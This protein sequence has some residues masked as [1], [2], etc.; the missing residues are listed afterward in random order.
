[1][2]VYEIITQGVMGRQISHD[3]ISQSP[4]RHRRHLRRNKLR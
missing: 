4:N 2:W 1:M 3:A